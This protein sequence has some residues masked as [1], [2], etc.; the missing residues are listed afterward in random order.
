[1]NSFWVQSG[2]FATTA[3]RKKEHF[4]LSYI[5]LLMVRTCIFKAKLWNFISWHKKKVCLWSCFTGRNREGVNSE[6]RCIYHFCSTGQ[7]SADFSEV[8]GPSRFPVTL[9]H[10]IAKCPLYRMTAFAYIKLSVP[11]NVQAEAHKIPCT[12]RKAALSSL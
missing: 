10:L 11:G 1:M 8:Q 7:S 5:L 9:R 2:T 3:S 12:G 4:H 6:I